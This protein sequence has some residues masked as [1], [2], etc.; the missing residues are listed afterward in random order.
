MNIAQLFVSLGVKGADKSVNS[1]M[2]LDKSLQKTQASSFITKAA[3]LGVFYAFQRLSKSSAQ[4]GA[5]L[6]NFNAEVG[7]SA[8]TLQRY[9]YAAR[10]VGVSNDQV[11]SSFKNLQ[12]A[13]TKNVLGESRIAGLDLLALKTKTT[14]KEL[15]KLLEQATDGNITPLFQKL[16]EYAGLETNE[17]LRNSVLSSFGVSGDMIAA[18]KQQAFTK[19]KLAKAQIYSDKD[20]ANLTKVN[21]AWDNLG[22]TIEKAFGKFNVAH[23]ESIVTNLGKIVKE[24]AALVEELAK[25]EKQVQ[26]FDKLAMAL[27]FAADFTKATRLTGEYFSTDDAAKKAS[28]SDQIKSLFLSPEAMAEGRRMQSEIDAKKTSTGGAT[29]S[30]ATDNKNVTVNQT[31]NFNGPTDPAKAASEN[32]RQLQNTL[33]QMSGQ[34][35]V[36]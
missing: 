32:K 13:A 1:I 23:G 3:I 25:L 28:L 21:A 5:S 30:Y 16:Q 36:N 10:Q 34:S 33:R 27:G 12:D 2:G 7:E 6:N 35:G 18:L 22:T 20:I 8:E 9:Q 19:D 4:T 14:G 15:A 31:L 11:A 17:G 29:G 26:V 24:V